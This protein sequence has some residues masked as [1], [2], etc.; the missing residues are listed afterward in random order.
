MPSLYVPWARILSLMPLG[1]LGSAGM[2]AIDFNRAAETVS[3]ASADLP[4]KLAPT[5]AVPAPRPVACP[6][7]P[8][9]L[10]TTA[11]PAGSTVHTEL[12]VR[13]PLVPSA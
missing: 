10:L 7:V 9:A 5:V 12:L 1:T 4:P 8:G 6:C 3:V 11:M 13:S 2:M